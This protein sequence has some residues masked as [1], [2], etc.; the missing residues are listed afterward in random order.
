MSWHI[1]RDCAGHLDSL[2]LKLLYTHN[3]TYWYHNKYDWS[4]S[5]F[6][7]EDVHLTKVTTKGDD[8]LVTHGVTPKGRIFSVW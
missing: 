1:S 4:P 6:V 8:L 3:L 2:E 5:Q 7:V